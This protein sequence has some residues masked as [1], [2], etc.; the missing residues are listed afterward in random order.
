MKSKEKS[1]KKQVHFLVDVEMYDS[2]KMLLREIGTLPS[3][4][5]NA[6]IRE[7]VEGTPTAIERR[8]EAKRRK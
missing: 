2:Y 1:K 6:Y 8:Y 5:F 4:D 7:C 3:Y